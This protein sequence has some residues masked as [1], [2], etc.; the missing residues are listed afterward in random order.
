MEFMLWPV[1]G[2]VLFV[3][4]IFILGYFIKTGNIM[5]RLRVKI[6]EAESGIDVALAKRFDTLTKLL[7]SVRSFT[8]HEQDTILNTIK[9]RQNMS[10]PERAQ[11]GEQL[12]EAQ[13]Q[14]N[15]L[16]EAYPTLTSQALFVQLQNAAMDTEEHLQAARRLYNSNVSTLNQMVVSFPSSMVA[17]VKSIQ[18]HPMFEAEAH[19]RSDVSLKM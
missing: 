12:A 8:K 9:L 10:I 6:K 18:Q 3:L 1:V 11:A 13:K 2:V 4:L 15:V 19:K 14:I 17:G 16:A 5:E 7:D